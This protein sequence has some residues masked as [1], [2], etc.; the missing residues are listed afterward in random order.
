[1]TD[2]ARDVPA[3]LPARRHVAKA[4]Q[5]AG[6]VSVPAPGR[7]PA[8]SDSEMSPSETE[9]ERER[10]IAAFSKAAAEQGYSRLDLATVARYAGVP[11]ARFQEHFASV[12]QA[13]VAGQKVFFRRLWLDIEGGCDPAAPWP[14]QIQAAVGCLIATLVETAATARLF[15]IEA[16]SASLA[17]AERQYTALSRL[18]GYLRTGRRLY[19][20]AAA[21]PEAT[22]RALIGGTVSIVCEHLLAEDPEEISRLQPQL[23][24]VLLSPYLGEEEAR[25][26]ACA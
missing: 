20:R 6:T 17:A 3:V 25:R 11:V 13:L 4:A 5:G 22:E 15:V 12:E 21:L 26:V 23:I 14:Q 18:A 24:E 7:L 10:L 1:M 8:L 2:G 16:P 19:P 9:D